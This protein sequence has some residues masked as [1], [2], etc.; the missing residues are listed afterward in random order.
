MRAMCGGWAK[1]LSK[2][3]EILELEKANQQD[4]RYDGS[5]FL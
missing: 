1:F 5:L 2:R 3:A 4:H